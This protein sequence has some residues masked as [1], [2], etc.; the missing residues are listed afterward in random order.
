MPDVA[1]ATGEQHLVRKAEDKIA[2]MAAPRR[3]NSEQDRAPGGR[4]LLRS[5]GTGSHESFRDERGASALTRGSPSPRSGR[6]RRRQPDD[7]VA[8]ERV[9]QKRRLGAV[10]RYPFQSAAPVEHVI[11]MPQGQ[12]HGRPVASAQRN[13]PKR[14]VPHPGEAVA[15]RRRSY[16]GKGI[17]R[18]EQPREPKQS[19]RAQAAHA[20]M[21]AGAAARRCVRRL[22]LR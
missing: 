3:R 13:H 18:P 10:W 16:R 2:R 15:S 12:Q 5:E 19:W 8:R 4:P 7:R 22:L 11:A 21:W 14:R 9:A 1:R 6:L 17:A 20:W